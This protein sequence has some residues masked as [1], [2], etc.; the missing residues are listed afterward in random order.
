[1]RTIYGE[2]ASHVFSVVHSSLR[3]ALGCESDTRK[4]QGEHLSVLSSFNFPFFSGSPLK[5]M[6]ATKEEKLQWL[7]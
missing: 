6:K 7:F 2:K 3:K 5:W 1:M 4:G